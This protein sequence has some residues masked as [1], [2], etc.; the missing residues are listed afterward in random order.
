MKT[1]LMESM[2]TADST[3]WSLNRD[4]MLDL[5]SSLSDFFSHGKVNIKTEIDE[6]VFG[7]PCQADVLQPSFQI[8]PPAYPGFQPAIS[9]KYAMRSRF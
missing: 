1:A 5:A 2:R 3:N 7:D 6:S 8:S 4:Q 9:G